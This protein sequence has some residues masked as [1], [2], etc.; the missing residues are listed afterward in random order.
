M[1]DKNQTQLNQSDDGKNTF[2]ISVLFRKN[3]T[4]QGTLKWVEGGREV[5]FRSA[6]ELIKLI[7][8]AHAAPQPG[9]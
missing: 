9:Q 4:W 3:A 6:L 7:D 5:T 1:N 2:N 8:G